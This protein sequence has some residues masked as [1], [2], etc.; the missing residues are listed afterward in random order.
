MEDAGLLNSI[1]GHE[2]AVSA[3]SNAMKEHQHMYI[4]SSKNPPPGFYVYAY[5]RKNGTPYYIGKGT[6]KRAYDTHRYKGKGVHVPTDNSFIMILETNLTEIGAFA[7]ERFYIRWYGRKDLAT[8]FLHNKTDGGEGASNDSEETR[9]KKS[10]P[11][12]LNGMFGKKRPREIIEKAAAASA[13]KTRGKTYEE[14]YGSEKAAA[15]KLQRSLSLRKPKSPEHAEK[16]RENGKKGGKSR[17]EK[18]KEKV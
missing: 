13:A 11:G 14:I 10:R 5:M 9:R 8:G 17:N 15:L 7:L 2:I 16:C 3:Y 12:I 18:R 1:V 6:G 4:Y